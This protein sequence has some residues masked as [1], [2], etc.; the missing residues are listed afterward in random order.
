MEIVLQ[1]ISWVLISIGAFALICGAVGVI[2]F[3]DIYTRMHAASITDT[4]GSASIL[5]ALIFQ[6][7]AS[8][9]SAKLALIIIFIFVTSPTS[10]FSLVHAALSSGVE[11]D[12]EH[13][14][15]D[16]HPKEQNK[17]QTEN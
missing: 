14:L 2:R 3:P 17:S 6:S 13:D 8:L 7:G 4:L 12:L 16:Q 1:I 11:P 5:L 9:V 15:R 10:S